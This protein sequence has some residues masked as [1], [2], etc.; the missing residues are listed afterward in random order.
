MTIEKYGQAND[1]DFGTDGKGSDAGL[2][3]VTSYSV[4]NTYATEIFLKDSTGAT[5]G[6]IQGDARTTGTITGYGSGS[7]VTLGTEFSNDLGVGD[8]SCAVSSVRASG[9]NED[10]TNYELSFNAFAGVSTTCDKNAKHDIEPLRDA[11][12]NDEM[13]ELAY[14]VSELQR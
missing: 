8:A 13:S 12:R 3:I 4:E 11:P 10:F 7:S 5:T 1:I 14:L 2:T 9:S 6:L